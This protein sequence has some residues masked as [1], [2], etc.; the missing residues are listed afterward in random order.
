MPT[1]LVTRYEASIHDP[2]ILDQHHEIGVLEAR[3]GFLLSQVDRGDAQS[4]WE[5]LQTAKTAMEE[6][7]RGGDVKAQG[8]HFATIMRLIDEGAGDAARWEEIYTV[9]G[10]RRTVVD[11]ERKRQVE[12]QA[13]MTAREAM[14]LVDVMTKAFYESVRRYLGQDPNADRIIRDTTNSLAKLGTTAGSS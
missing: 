7:R 13:M 1:H 11:S 14:V 9:I 8:K 2:D 5:Q 10:R 6:A 3:L 4:H 12:M